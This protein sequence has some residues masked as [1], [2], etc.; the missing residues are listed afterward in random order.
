MVKYN[1]DYNIGTCYRCCKCMYCSCNLNEKKCKCDKTIKPNKKNWTKEVPY[2]FT[3]TF[4]EDISLCKKAFIQTK[5]KLYSY[6]NSL[7]QKFTFTFC[8]ICNNQ[9]QKLSNQKIEKSTVPENFNN[10]NNKNSIDSFIIDPNYHE[11]FIDP[12]LLENLINS[13]PEVVII[14]HQSNNTYKKNEEMREQQ[15]SFTLIVKKVDGKL[16]P[17]KWLTLNISTFKKFAVQVQKFIGITIGVEDID[18]N[19]GILSFF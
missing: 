18:Q 9:F 10:F 6:N 4:K 13:Q 16:L 2:A 12:Q 1:I 8:S 14:D 11:E 3:R 5:K 15:I 19:D 7:K 17:R